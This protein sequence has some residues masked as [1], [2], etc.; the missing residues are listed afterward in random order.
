MQY[1]IARPTLLDKLCK[2]EAGGP[3]GAKS[4]NSVPGTPLNRGNV[5]ERSGGT[6]PEFP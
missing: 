3:V 1:S 4:L 5:F 2:N 6:T